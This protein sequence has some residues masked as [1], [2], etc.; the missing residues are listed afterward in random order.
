[1]AVFARVVD[2]GSFS[3]A[4]RSLGIAKSAVSRHVACWRAWA[5]ACSTAPPASC[6]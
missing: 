2:D 3:G 4:A 6:T 5:C 1:M